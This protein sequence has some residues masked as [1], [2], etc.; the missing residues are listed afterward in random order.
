LHQSSLK[1]FQDGFTE[2]ERDFLGSQPALDAL[3]AFNCIVNVLEALEI[4]ESVEFVFR[5]ESRTGSVLCSCTLRMRLF[6]TPVYKV[7]DRFVMM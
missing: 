6:V 4:N 2:A 7:F 1:P 3:L 5:S